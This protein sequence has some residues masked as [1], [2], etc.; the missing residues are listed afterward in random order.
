[1]IT[2]LISLTVSIVCHTGVIQTVEISQWPRSICSQPNTSI[3]MHCSQDA[4]YDY[5][6]WY[7]HLPGEGPKLM[8]SFVA[9]SAS[10]E[11]EFKS[12]FRVWRTESSERLS[13]V[14]QWS[15]TVQMVQRRDQAVYLCAASP[16]GHVKCAEFHQSPSLTVKERDSVE[17]HCSHDDS[18]LLVMLWYQQRQASPAMTLIGYGYSTTEPNYEGLFK[19][20]F[21][22]K[23]ADTLKGTLVISNLTLADSAVE[24]DVSVTLQCYHDDSSY[25][26][27]F[28]YRQRDNNNMEMLTYSPGQDVWEIEPPFEKTKY[29]MGR[30]KL[31]NSSLE[32]NNVEGCCENTVTSTQPAFFGNGTKLT[33]LDPNINVKEPTVKVLPPST[34]ECEARNKKK[35]KTLGTDNKALRDK[36]GIFYSITSRLRVPA[37]DWNKPS[38]KFTCIVEFFNWTVSRNETDHINGE[39]GPGGDGGMTAEYYVN[40]T[41]I[42]KLAYSVFI[43]KSTFYGLVVM[44]LIWKLQLS[45]DKQM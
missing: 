3:D 23:R 36:D 37:K 8:A 20:R 44:V 21:Q 6:Y 35:K 11:A 29:T 30:P 40:S 42:A 43:A 39:E 24:G 38:N 22:L 1:M 32:I 25:Y 14:R 9:G 17:V 18:S 41:L 12:G 27:M 45:S 26:Y 4:G 31:T 13:S 33:V 15:L 16:H 28:W 10:Y 19:E 2:V 5:M 7:R 34:K